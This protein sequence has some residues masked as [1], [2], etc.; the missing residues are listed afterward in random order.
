MVAHRLLR[1]LAGG[2]AV[3]AALLVVVFGLPALNRAVPNDRSLTGQQ[4]YE[5]GAGVSVQ[6]PPSARIDA[7][8][9]RPGAD[10]AAVLFLLGAVRYAIVVTPFDGG[11]EDAAGRLRTKIKATQGYQVTGDED[12]VRTASGIDGLA[13]GYTAPGRCGRYAV[14][15]TGGVSI[16]VTVSGAEF[17]LGQVISGIDASIDSIAYGGGR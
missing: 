9:T 3:L 2:T 10:R 1:N 13:G 14:F 17:E 11:I 15:L 5:V 16:E 6:P 8:K 7:S 4:R 12:G